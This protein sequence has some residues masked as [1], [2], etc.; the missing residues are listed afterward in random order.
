MPSLERARRFKR[1]G[2]DVA[3]AGA[4]WGLIRSVVWSRNDPPSNPMLGA[5]CDDHDSVHGSR[6]SLGAEHWVGKTFGVCTL[7]SRVR[8]I[9]AQAG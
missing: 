6:K 1:F 8:P 2:S 5:N 9:P 7:R 3:L 4:L